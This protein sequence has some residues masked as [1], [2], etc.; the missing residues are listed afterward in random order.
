MSK[1]Q[2]D[3]RTGTLPLGP[4]KPRP[5]KKDIPLSREKKQNQILPVVPETE[6]STQPSH[7]WNQLSKNQPIIIR[8]TRE[9][10]REIQAELQYFDIGVEEVIP[11]PSIVEEQDQLPIP[12]QVP[13]DAEILSDEVPELPP[14]VKP[15]KKRKKKTATKSIDQDLEK[16]KEEDRFPFRK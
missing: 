1:L 4:Q 14:L 2:W 16:S 12:Q 11:P 5:V 15:R 6:D 7:G 10:K 3:P 13:I 9:Q 8:H